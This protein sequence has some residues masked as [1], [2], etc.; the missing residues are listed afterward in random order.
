MRIHSGGVVSIPEGIALGSGLNATAA[1]TL[2]DYEEG[3]FTPVITFGGA[4][5]GITYTAGR[6][7][8]IYTKVGNLVTYS[9]HIQLT[10]K[11]SSTGALQVTGVPFTA[12]NNDKY[13]PGA[14]FI[15]SMSSMSTLPIFRVTPNSTVMDCYQMVSSSYAQVTNSNCTNNSGFIISGQ[16]YTDS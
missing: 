11:G 15:Q 2:D 8:G 7:S 4:S 16:F 9:I 12:S 6:Q 13:T 3:T 5:V 14:A 10:N 1:N